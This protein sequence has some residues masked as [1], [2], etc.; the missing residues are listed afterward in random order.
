MSTYFL[1]CLCLAGAALCVAMLMQLGY[2]DAAITLFS[3]SCV[4]G[5][6]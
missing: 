5:F 6:V 3:V 2:T 4:P 1:M